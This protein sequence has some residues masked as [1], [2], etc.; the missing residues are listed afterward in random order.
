VDVITDWLM[1]S[2]MSAGLELYLAVAIVSADW[3]AHVMIHNELDSKCC[4]NMRADSN[5]Q[6][7]A[8][9]LGVSVV[10]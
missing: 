2:L 8:I 1:W 9:D 10:C 5:V 6:Q 4:I 3:L 7:C